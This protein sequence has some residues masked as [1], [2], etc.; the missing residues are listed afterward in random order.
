MQLGE[1][2]LFG[3][4]NAYTSVIWEKFAVE[5]LGNGKI[6]APTDTWTILRDAATLARTPAKFLPAQAG[7]AP[8]S[9]KLIA[10][11]FSQTGEVLRGWYFNHLNTKKGKPVFDGAVV[12]SD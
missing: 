3:R 7:T 12:G 5:A 6:V 11:G 9:G 8:T 2:F 1:D 10:Y 4:G